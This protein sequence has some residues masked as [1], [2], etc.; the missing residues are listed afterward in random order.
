[1][2]NPIRDFAGM[3][4]PAMKEVAG[5]AFE[6]HQAII[7]AITDSAE[8]VCGEIRELKEILRQNLT[9]D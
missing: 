8:L 6:S 5:A 3:P 1:M 2:S 7:K 9:T 4:T